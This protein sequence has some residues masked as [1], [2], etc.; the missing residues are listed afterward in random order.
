MRILGVLWVL[1]SCGELAAMPSGSVHPELIK[2][3]TLMG[4]QVGSDATIE[5]LNAIAQKYFL[6]PKKSERLDEKARSFYESVYQGLGPTRE[7]KVHEVMSSFKT[8]G[9]SDAVYPEHVSPRFVLIQGSTLSNMANRLRFTSQLLESGK[10]KP[11]DTEFIMMAGERK[12]FPNEVTRENLAKIDPGLANEGEDLPDLPGE[13]ECAQWLVS[14]LDKFAP[15]LGAQ[16]VK[17]VCASK[18]KASGRAETSDAAQQF[19]SRLTPQDKG[20]ILIVSSNPFVD[21]QAKTFMLALRKSKKVD[22]N[23]FQVVGVGSQGGYPDVP[24]YVQMGVFLDNLARS[25]YVETQLRK[26]Q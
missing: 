18:Q 11:Q 7:D 24:I 17:L 19:F 20:E 3:F 25:L 1:A 14:H 6:R 22:P 10:L 21:Y 23:V 26:L 8:L 13:C 5:E 12:V 16:K 4:H 9:Y 15:A 2:I